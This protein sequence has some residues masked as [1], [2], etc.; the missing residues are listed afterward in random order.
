MHLRENKAGYSKGWKKERQGMIKLHFDFNKNC[1]KKREEKAV[2]KEV[3]L[4]KT[5][6]AGGELTFGIWRKENTWE[7]KD[8]QL[9]PKFLEV[10]EEKKKKIRTEQQIHHEDYVGIP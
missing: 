6:D 7:K 2:D 8:A 9:S 1:K 4:E 5:H 10:S 3:W